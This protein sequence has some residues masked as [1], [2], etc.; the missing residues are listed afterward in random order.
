MAIKRLILFALAT[1]YLLIGCLA[2]DLDG[3]ADDRSAAI[4]DESME[5]NAG[6]AQLF[7]GDFFQKLYPKIEAKLAAKLGSTEDLDAIMSEVEKM[8]EEEKKAKGL[9]KNEALAKALDQIAAFR[10]IREGNMCN[11]NSR[12]IIWKNGKAI[13]PILA[14]PLTNIKTLFMAKVR[15]HAEYCKDKYQAL[16]RP[17]YAAFDSFSKRSLE[18]VLD[19]IIMG[20][21][22]MMNYELN[23][24]REYDAR[25]LFDTWIASSNPP[26][27]KE[28]SFGS[29]D[30]L[31]Y[32][33]IQ[34]IHQDD[35]N[36]EKKYLVMAN[37][38][39][40]V[41][42]IKSQKVVKE[43]FIQPC[44]RYLDQ[45]KDIFDSAQYDLRV[46]KSKGE[47][48]PLDE[49]D[50]DFF[51]GWARYKMCASLDLRV[52]DEHFSRFNYFFINSRA[53]L[54]EEMR[55]VHAAL[56]MEKVFS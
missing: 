24:E 25:Y 12:A 10:R 43:Y 56:A 27:K 34:M 47:E 50:K 28:L 54:Q 16:F 26:V 36:S 4:A 2:D 6:L 3:N 30:I 11:K 44:E 49:K 33:I 18:T 45:F 55:G 19:H 46:L 29:Q 20:N 31:Y 21:M 7:V 39:E 22:D 51:A 41:C 14:S 23:S 38:R 5:S 9:F 8:A 35:P 37:D 40:V 48:F 13:G 1:N 32:H 42:Y 53:T 17:R 52:L 15:E